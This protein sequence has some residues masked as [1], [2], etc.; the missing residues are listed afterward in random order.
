QHTAIRIQ[1]L[2]LDILDNT[3]I[4]SKLLELT[5]DNAK[6]MIAMGH[7][8]KTELASKGNKEL[9]HQ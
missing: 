8:L 5:T 4:S 2:L 7:D 6:S 9:I 1:E 3:N